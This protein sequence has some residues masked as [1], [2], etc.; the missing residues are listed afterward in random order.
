M[1]RKIVAR[2]TV[3]TCRRCGNHGRLTRLGCWVYGSE[4]IADHAT[5]SPTG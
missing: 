5:C 2:L 4:R 1:L 3:N